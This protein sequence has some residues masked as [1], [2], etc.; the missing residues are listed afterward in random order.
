MSKSIQAYPLQ[1]PLNIKRT[2]PTHRE[3]AR[4]VVDAWDG[5]NHNLSIGVEIGALKKALANEPDWANVITR[6]FTAADR[7]D[8]MALIQ[9]TQELR[10]A[11]E[12][13]ND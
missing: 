10:E 9:T 2:P 6:H 8:E 11:L 3:Y 13:Y 12:K 4:A 7:R 5:P 1:W